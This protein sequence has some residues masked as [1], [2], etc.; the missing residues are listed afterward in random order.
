V[1][2]WE[3]IGCLESINHAHPESTSDEFAIVLQNDRG[4]VTITPKSIWGVQF[5]ESK[6]PVAKPAV[7]ELWNKFKKAS[8]EHTAAM[9]K[10]DGFSTMQPFADMEEI[11]TKLVEIGGLPKTLDHVDFWKTCRKSPIG[12]CVFDSERGHDGEECIYCG[13]PDYKEA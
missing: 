1:K 8:K 2:L 3:L 12:R 6:P 9:K 13:R 7:V 11:V 10:S 5:I 4:G